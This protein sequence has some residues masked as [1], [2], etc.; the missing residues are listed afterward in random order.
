MR[1]ERFIPDDDV[2]ARMR[3]TY[4]AR[5]YVVVEDYFTMDFVRACREELRALLRCVRARA[6][7]RSRR[8]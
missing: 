7:V 4:D 6:R 3:E 2:L 1:V 5:G 8:V